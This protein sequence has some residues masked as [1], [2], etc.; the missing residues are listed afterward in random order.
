MHG[1]RGRDADTYIEKNKE[2]A[3]LK[4]RERKMRDMKGE[5]SRRE[6]ERTT[7]YF[8]LHSLQRTLE[9]DLI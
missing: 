3:F 1:K 9:Q 4:E 2:R 6:R 5:K 7:D 8:S